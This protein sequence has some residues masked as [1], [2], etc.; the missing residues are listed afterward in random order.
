MKRVTR[1][2]LL[3]ILLSGLLYSCKKSGGDSNNGNNFS[4]SIRS[5]IPQ[6]V[7]DSLRSWGL[8]IHDGNTPPSITGIYLLSPD[9]CVFDNS[10]FD[11]A[12][13]LFDDYKFRF[14]NQTS[15]TIRVERKN[16]TDDTDYAADSSATFIAGNGSYFT[17]FAQEKGSESGV[18]YTSLSIYTGQITSAGIAGFQ[19]ALY[20]KTKDAD[21]G[22]VLV[23]AK[24]SRIFTNSGG[25]VVPISTFAIDPVLRQHTFR[26]L[27]L[28]GARNRVRVH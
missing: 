11:M 15:Q 5:I 8:N 1:V 9:S 22:G 17:I 14:S 20:L 28:A 24:T 2:C 4:D 6:P 21:P 25:P 16:A 26:L 13:Q 23:P 3:V 19:I 18:S 7:I 10:G 27:S 12:G